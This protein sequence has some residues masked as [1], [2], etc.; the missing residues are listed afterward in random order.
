VIVAQCTAYSSSVYKNTV[1]HYTQR[2]ITTYTVL[3]DT[4]MVLQPQHTLICCSDRVKVN[5]H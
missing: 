3:K 2:L 5:I 4:K 1:V